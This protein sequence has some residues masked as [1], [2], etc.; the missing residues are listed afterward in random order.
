MITLR[1]TDSQN[2]DFIDLVKLLDADLKIR[3]GE[4][5]AFYSQFN[6]IDR[7]KYA[8]VAYDDER[9]VGCGALKVHEPQSIEVKRMFVSPESRG[10]GVAAKILNELERWAAELG[11]DQCQLETGTRQPEAIA[12]Y[13]KMGYRVIENYGQYAGIANSVCFGKQ[14]VREI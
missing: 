12:L 5:H 14:F 11:Y 7:I 1:R 9:P 8:V 3:D 13:K 10:K 2:Q 4:D 6:Q